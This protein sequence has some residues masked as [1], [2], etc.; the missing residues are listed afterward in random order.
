MGLIVK[1]VVRTLAVGAAAYLVPG[2]RIDNVWA[3]VVAVIVLGILNSVV[4]PLLLMLTIPV[5]ILT[6]GLFTLVINTIMI[7]LA[8]ELVPGFSVN[9]FWT[10]FWFSIVLTL[11][12]WFLE[13]VG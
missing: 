9:G 2:V 5:N 6:L 1:L 4:R 10:A 8:A 13:Q 11:V 3:A 12:N 7:L